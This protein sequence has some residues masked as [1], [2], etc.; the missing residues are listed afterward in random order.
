MIIKN[1]KLKNYNYESA[2]FTLVKTQQ[3][4]ISVLKLASYL[5]LLFDFWKP[6][7][8]E[9]EIDLEIMKKQVENIIAIILCVL[10]WKLIIKN[11]I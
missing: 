11:N 1:V 7:M 4:K 3:N 6:E 8:T 9:N 2:S 5:C 10:I